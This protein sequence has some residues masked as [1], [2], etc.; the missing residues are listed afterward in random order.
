VPRDGAR[1]PWG[2]SVETSIKS[3]TW[4]G[5]RITA[6]GLYVGIPLDRYHSGDICDAP[7]IS[8]SGLR[9]LWTSSPA[10]YWDSS[11]L[12]PKGATPAENAD[13]ILGRAVHHLVAG[14]RGF[15]RYFIIRPQ[16]IW[17]DEKKQDVEWHGNRPACKKWLK[18]AK[19]AG[20]SVL[21]MDD[22]EAIRSMGLALE[23]YP[24]VKQGAL[25]GL[26]ERS[27]FWKDEETGIWLKA[28][29][30]VIPTASGDFVDLKTTTST[31]YNDLQKSLFDYSYQM[32]AALVFEGARALGLETH[33]FT[34]LWVQKRRPFCVRHSSL[35]DADLALGHR[36]NRV[37]IR[38]FA[39][40]LA[41]Q[42]W[43]QPGDSDNDN[44]EYLQ[45]SDR[46]RD[47]IE[48]RLSILEKTA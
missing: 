2:T 11:P 20:R 37:M 40:S 5:R 31:I 19:A 23:R 32:Q 9:K 4:D 33:S 39:K 46:A 22:V 36:M 21:T 41:A 14:E 10:E 29:P 24:L 43:P 44:S 45:L 6:P 35:I 26:I 38:Q 34:L 1:R 25:K 27:L 17:D 28:R 18:A 30:D 47:I 7:S 3:I 13:F 15:S 48:S 42:S 8:S 12:N 16:R